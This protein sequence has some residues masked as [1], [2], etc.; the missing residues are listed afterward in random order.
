MDD[1]WLWYIFMGYSGKVLFVKFLLDN[2]WIVLGSY[3]W[4]FK[5]WDLCSK[6]CIKIVFVGFSCNDI[7]CIE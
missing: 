7:V 2:V 4:I 5:F 1:Y 3:D 6:V